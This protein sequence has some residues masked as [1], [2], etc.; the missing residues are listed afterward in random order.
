MFSSTSLPLS[1]ISS[2]SSPSS[3]SSKKPR[4]DSPLLPSPSEES[5]LIWKQGAGPTTTGSVL[6][7]LAQ[8]GYTKEV[9]KIIELSRISS[10]VGR[11]SAGGLP[12]LWDVMGRRRGKGGITRLMAV[13]ITRGPLSPQR[14]RSLIQDHNASLREKDDRG[15]TALHHALG[16]RHKA[17]PI[18]FFYEEAK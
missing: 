12:E 8:N 18:D 10:L 4:I 9:C 17:D 11:K 1:T 16:V 6:V 5:T 3:S 14:A 2:S 13:C 7:K 15:R